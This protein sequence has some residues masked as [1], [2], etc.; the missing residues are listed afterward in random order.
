MLSSFERC[1]NRWMSVIISLACLLTGCGSTRYAYFQPGD[2]LAQHATPTMSMP[3][4]DTV[5][6]PN[7]TSATPAES[8]STTLVTAS[9]STTSRSFSAVQPARHRNP[10]S[11][12]NQRFRRL[13]G[14]GIPV[15]HV[16][17]Q[18]RLIDRHSASRKVYWL[19]LAAL[20]MAVASASL[21]FWPIG[22][23]LTW[24]LAISMPLTATLLGVASLT[25]ISQHKDRY[26]GK[27]W[28]VAAILLGT[29][30]IGLAVVAMAALSV[31]PV[32][33]EK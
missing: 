15:A 29:G 22:T 1:N 8:V 27:G 21:F 20:G 6:L 33:W 32:V 23:A 31:S 2:R 30:L 16:A 26:R 19:S 7:S 5:L 17:P 28:A 18:S 3:L 25:T 4:A 12:H 24:I 11:Y 9:L 14:T 13:A 10:D